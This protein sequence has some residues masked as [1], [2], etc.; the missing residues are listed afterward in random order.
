M[1]HA[2]KTDQHPP[3]ALLAEISS[4]ERERRFLPQGGSVSASPMNIPPPALKLTLPFGTSFP[5]PS[6]TFPVHEMRGCRVPFVSDRDGPGWMVTG[7]GP[8]GGQ[9][10]VD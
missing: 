1:F 9:G 8:R 10:F 6:S 3:E 7:W 4:M 5:K 2:L